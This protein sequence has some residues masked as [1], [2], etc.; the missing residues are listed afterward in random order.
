MQSDEILWVN[1]PM[2][3]VCCTEP[4]R[5]STQA[6]RNIARK[7]FDQV[8]SRRTKAGGLAI[9][10]STH[11]LQFEASLHSV[12]SQRT[13]WMKPHSKFIGSSLPVGRLGFCQIVVHDL[14]ER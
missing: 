10:L 3:I 1:E 8:T 13:R 9:H 6:N 2:T 4:G 7:P 5:Q 14:A 12:C 11:N